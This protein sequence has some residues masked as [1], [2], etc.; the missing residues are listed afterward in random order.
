MK[1]TETQQKN[2]ANNMFKFFNDKCVKD[3]TYPKIM[4]FKL[5]NQLGYEL[6]NDIF[7]QIEGF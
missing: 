3:I 1:L 4:Y 5:D 6:L 7:V 2:L